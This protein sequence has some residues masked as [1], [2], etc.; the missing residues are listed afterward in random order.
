MNKLEG[1]AGGGYKLLVVSPFT[2]DSKWLIFPRLDPTEVKTL[3]HISKQSHHAP[4][5][6]TNSALFSKAVTVSTQM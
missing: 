2:N 3:C 6:V 1:R 5:I 4:T